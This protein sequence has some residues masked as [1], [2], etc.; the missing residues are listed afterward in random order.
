LRYSE[1]LNP[2]R[3]VW[4]MTGTQASRPRSR[5]A[6]LALLVILPLVVATVEGVVHTS[7]ASAATRAQ[8]LHLMDA[9]GA[10]VV[11]RSGHSGDHGSGDHHGDRHHDEGDR[12]H[13]EGDRH[14]DEGDR[15][16]DEGDRH[17]DEGDRHHDEGGDH[18]GA[19]CHNCGID[20]GDHREGGG[21]GD[22]NGG[23]HKGG[24]RGGC[25]PQ[26]ESLLEALLDG[27]C[28]GAEDLERALAGAR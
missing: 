27:L 3:E 1:I 24:E 9:N 28:T 17:H 26:R 25:A 7:P 11:D 8:V 2:E 20:N 15:H 16:H 6:K 22:H 4:G 13:D 21:E 18:H 5:L 10:G 19:E 14:H 23:D 12:H